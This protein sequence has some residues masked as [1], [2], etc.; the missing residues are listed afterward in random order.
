M[1]V[2]RFL[3]A[4]FLLVATIAAVADATPSVYGAGSFKATALGAHWED[5]APSSYQGAH[6]AVAGLSPW[7]WDSLIAPVLA[8][9]T[10]VTFGALA[11]AS[12]Y[13]GRR[14]KTVRIFVN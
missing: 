9:P 6:K 4:V 3:A 1:A 8:V 13:A 2:F 10:F 7:V 5:F 14:R 11:L 12:G